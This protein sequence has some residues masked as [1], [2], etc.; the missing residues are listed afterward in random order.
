MEK[1][2]HKK[3]GVRFLTFANHPPTEFFEVVAFIEGK[4]VLY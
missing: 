2:Y 1:K 4:H 3:R